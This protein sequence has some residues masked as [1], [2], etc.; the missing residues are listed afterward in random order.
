M[1]KKLREEGKN[2]LYIDAKLISSK[3][4][5]LSS[6]MSY[7]G[8]PYPNRGV[9]SDEILDRIKNLNEKLVV[10]IDEADLFKDKELLYK[11]TKSSIKIM[12]VLISNVPSLTKSLSKL[13][14][15]L[16]T[17]EFPRYSPKEIKDILIERA[18]YGLRINSYDGDIIGKIAGF[19]AKHKGNARAAIL[20]LFHS[21]LIAEEKG[22][23]KISIEDVEEAKEKLLS[24]LIDYDFSR[25]QGDKKIVLQLLLNSQYLDIDEIAKRIG[26]SEKT[27]RN[28]LNELIESGFVREEKLKAGKIEKTIYSIKLKL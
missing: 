6:I 3:I 13:S 1:V 27:T 5:F 20:L 22:K 24:E 9:S 26:K 19:A 7:M 12:F 25:F 23:D 21:A 16:T 8:K 15:Q 17:V 2:A 4:P 10:F 18:K 28:I 11:L 14:S